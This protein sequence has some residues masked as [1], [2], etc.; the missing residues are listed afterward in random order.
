MVHDATHRLDSGL[1]V[2]VFGHRDGT[3]EILK[4]SPST[5]RV[6]RK[7]PELWLK[8]GIDSE[9]KIDWKLLRATSSVLDLFISF[10]MN[11]FMIKFNYWNDYY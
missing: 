1:D 9:G 5:S 7:E 11:L 4:N 2:D 10:E 6:D 3:D 8:L